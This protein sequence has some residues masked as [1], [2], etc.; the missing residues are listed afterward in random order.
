VTAVFDRLDRSGS[1]RF[2]EFVELALYGP[3][4]F[5]AA[6]GG[7]GRSGGDFLTSPEVGPL[8]GAVVARYLDAT[9]ERLGHPDEFVVV[10][11][12]AGRGALAISVLAAAPACAPA[13]RYV[14]VERSPVLRARQ[15][16]HLP[17]AEPFLV[18]GSSREGAELDDSPP[19]PSGPSGTSGSPG[20][21]G[22]APEFAR[23]GAVGPIVVSLPDLPA[24]AVTGVVIANE[25]LDNLPFRL[26][27]RT[28][29]GWVEVRVVRAAP[30]L[31]VP[32]SAAGG[33]SGLA[34]LLVPADDA[35]AA[36]ADR[37]APDAPVGARVPLQDEAGGWLRSAFGVIDR[38]SVLVVDYAVATSAELAA[39]PWTEWVRTYVGHG[40]GG[41][42]LD[43]P[44]SQDVTV[45][46]AVDQ[47]S[48]VRE[49]S[50]DTSQSDWLRK[51][52][53]EQL[54]DEGR[55]AWEAGAGR[56]HLE[57]LRGR[58]RIAEAESL[59]DPSGLGA[60]R[61]LEWHLP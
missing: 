49:P 21:S 19:G 18:L 53:I 29:T 51:W 42:P 60:F 5:Y 52:G 36:R 14:L 8:F 45:E 46:I 9:W 24:E 23:A 25:L 11:A 1:I 22:S 35:T 57:A 32:G 59:C 17:L 26:L 61:V 40:R 55:R 20:P 58:S 43:G 13:L 56:G 48:M 38:G 12:A 33:G 3:G 34:E 6:G 30:D 7:A 28:G 41:D 39:R 54:V 44:G 27:E 10:E 31:A 4:G 47:L 15:A 37:L 16:E 50:V 2:D